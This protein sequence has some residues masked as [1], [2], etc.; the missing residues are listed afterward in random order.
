MNTIKTLKDALER[1]GEIL[2]SALSKSLAEYHKNPTK[3]TLKDYQANKTAFE[4]YEE[5]QFVDNNPGKMTFKN[6]NEVWAHL[7]KEGYKISEKSPSKIYKDEKAGLLSKE[8]GNKVFTSADVMRY[9]VVARLSMADGSDPELDTILELRAKN[10]NR[11]AATRA[12]KLKFE[13]DVLKDRYILISDLEKE[14]SQRAALLK[15]GI[16]GFFILKARDVINA[17]EG[18]PDI[19]DDFID[20]MIDA[21][22]EHFDK[23]S[24][25]IDFEVSTTNIEAEKEDN[26]HSDETSQHV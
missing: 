20:Y 4:E 3:I 23:Y 7:I 24:K 22:E 5:K 1:E 9:I 25:E 14:L 13:Y 8:K 17:C 18:N 6:A 19:K 2:A 11:L 16:E 12:D 26:G 21:L 10:E 15:S